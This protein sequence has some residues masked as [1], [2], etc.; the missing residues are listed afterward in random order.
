MPNELF[1][2][3]Y[4][5]PV[6]MAHDFFLQVSPYLE[7]PRRITKIVKIVKF[8]VA[9]HFYAQGSYQNSVG[10]DSRCPMSQSAVSSCI[11]DVTNGIVNNFSGRVIKYPST[12]HEITQV[13]NGFFQ[14]FQFAGVIGVIDGTHISIVPP[15][16]GRIP[17]R[18]VFLNRKNYYSINCQIIL[19]QI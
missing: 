19:M 4:R 14:N 18:A 16:F 10:T 13:K 1:R 9:L 7:E 12:L 6:H 8:I 17:P 15:V 5:F 2:K 11:T 3:L